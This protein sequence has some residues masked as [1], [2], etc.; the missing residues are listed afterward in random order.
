M[1][2]LVH[3]GELVGFRLRKLLSVVAATSLL[4]ATPSIATPALDGLEIK[5]SGEAQG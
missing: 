2:C 3:T 1:N 5:L 4:M